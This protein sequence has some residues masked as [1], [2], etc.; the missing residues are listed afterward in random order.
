MGSDR[1]GNGSPDLWSR[2]HLMPMLVSVE[3]RGGGM[4]EQHLIEDRLQLPGGDPSWS[5]GRVAVSLLTALVALGFAYYVAW[6][7]L[8]LL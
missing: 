6:A 5:P 3:R 8:I 2:E 1:L 4:S 7:F